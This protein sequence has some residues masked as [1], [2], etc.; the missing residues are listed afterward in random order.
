MSGLFQNFMGLTKKD[1]KDMSKL[2]WIKRLKR[3]E[4]KWR[5]TCPK[6]ASRAVLFC[7]EPLPS[8]PLENASLS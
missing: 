7:V 2:K 4:K 6:K 5:V 1:K 8:K 3:E